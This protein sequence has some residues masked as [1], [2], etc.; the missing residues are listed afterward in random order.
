M[1]NA[2][3]ERRCRPCTGETPPLDS[4]K[5]LE[6]LAEL[7]EWRIVDGKLKRDFPMADMYAAADLVSGIAAIAEAEDHHPDLRVTWRGVYVTIWTHA[8]QAL[9][10]NDFILAAKIDRLGIRAARPIA[11]L[12]EIALRV[13]DLDIMHDFY[14][15]VIHL[16]PMKRFEKISFFRI[17]SGYRGHSQILALFDRSTVDGTLRPNG[18]TSTLDHIA[19]TIPLSAYATER[20]RLEAAGFKVETAEHT[21]VQWR[22]LC[23]R[24][25]E[26]N[27]VELICFDSSV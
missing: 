8:I 11:A 24:D 5:A 7:G 17:A 18:S 20:A 3:G 21:W 14:E 13:A 4:K 26:G 6:L 22:S 19:F 25:P 10:E 9:S 12:G 27:R 15:H 1:S 23:V 2:L 16:E